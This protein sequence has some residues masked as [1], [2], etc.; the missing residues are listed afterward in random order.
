MI[1]YHNQAH[2]CNQ[3]KIHMNYRAYEIND[4]HCL[5]NDADYKINV[6][7]IEINDDNIKH[8]FK[9]KNISFF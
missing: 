5:I 8:S 6:P 2:E 7:C 9:K 3:H 1:R 4:L